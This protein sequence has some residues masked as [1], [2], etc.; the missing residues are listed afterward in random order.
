MNQNRHTSTT[1]IFYSDQYFII[2]IIIISIILFVWC[3]KLAHYNTESYLKML[4]K[5]NVLRTLQQNGM[6]DCVNNVENWPI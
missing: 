5:Y 1:C 3:V 6:N 4:A 2:I